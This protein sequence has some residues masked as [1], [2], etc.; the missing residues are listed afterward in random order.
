MGVHRVV[1]GD[2]RCDVD[3]AWVWDV[4]VGG[5]QVDD[6]DGAL[7]GSKQLVFSVAIGRFTAS[8]STADDLTEWHGGGEGE[9]LAT[10]ITINLSLF[11]DWNFVYHSSQLAY[12]T[13]DIPGRTDAGQ[14]PSISTHPASAYLHTYGTIPLLGNFL[15]SLRPNLSSQ[16]PL[17]E[18]S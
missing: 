7:E 6:G 4:V 17:D 12:A 11:L 13:E 3:G 15:A 2:E 16:G 8:W 5:V 9:S 1:E 10:L 18:R 14:H